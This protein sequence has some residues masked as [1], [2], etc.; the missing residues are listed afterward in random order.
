MVESNTF[1]WNELRTDDQ[2]S[3]GA[4]YSQLFGWERSEVDAGP[5]G[6]YTIFRRDGTDVA[7]MMNPTAPDYG[8]SPPPK[9][10]A[11]IAVDDCD[12]V[13]ARAVE[14]GA[15]LIEPPLDVAGVGRICMFRDVVGAQVYVLQ[16]EAAPA[17]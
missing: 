17:S 8:G 15:T 12:A 16:P 7:G 4:F 11:Y 2:P 9:W 14:L 3:A 5:L 10:I 6:T 1:M 13:A